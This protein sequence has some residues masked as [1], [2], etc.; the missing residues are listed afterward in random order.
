MATVMTT[1]YCVIASF[2]KDVQ[3]QGKCGAECK[4]NDYYLVDEHNKHYD[5]LTDNMDCITRYVRNKRQY[6]E[7]Q[8]NRYS[9]RHCILK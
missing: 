8:E 2:V 3:E 5:I 1:R 9:T 7:E 6:T 4:K